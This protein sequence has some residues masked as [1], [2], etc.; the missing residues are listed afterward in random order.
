MKTAKITHVFIKMFK[1]VN[2]QRCSQ[3]QHKG[4]NRKFDSVHGFIWSQVTTGKIVEM[5]VQCEQAL[6]NTSITVIVNTTW[7][8]RDW[9]IAA[10]SHHNI[11]T[12]R[13]ISEEARC[14]E[15][16]SQWG[17]CWSLLLRSCSSLVWLSRS[18]LQA[19]N[20][21]LRVSVRI[22]L[23]YITLLNRTQYS[24]ATVDVTLAS[25]LTVQE[26]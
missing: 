4:L 3:F 5:L 8:N 18:P 17:V 13:H 14:S 26:G 19:A 16:T 9:G 20:A 6:R 15:G 10:L 21:L 12:P 2:H 23:I 11:R 7:I 24:L 25:R 1:T 22:Q